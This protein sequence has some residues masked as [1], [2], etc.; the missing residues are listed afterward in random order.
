MLSLPITFTVVRMWCNICCDVINV[1]FPLFEKNVQTG[2]SMDAPLWFSILNTRLAQI[3][4]GHSFALLLCIETVLFFS[5][6]FCVINVILT[7]F[8]S[9]RF[10][11]FS[12]QDFP[13][14]LEELD[15][16]D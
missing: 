13:I 2:K 3:L 14:V 15:I 5:S 10:L 16:A 9:Y 8:A 12:F 1:I 4:T 7:V 11:L 6:F